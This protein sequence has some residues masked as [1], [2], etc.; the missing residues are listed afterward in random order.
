[1]LGEL[2][3]Q[4]RVV[5]FVTDS[6]ATTVLLNGGPTAVPLGLR[7]L[8]QEA[9]LVEEFRFFSITTPFPLMR[10]GM[11]LG[12]HDIC[13]DMPLELL[14]R[15]FD[16]SQELDLSFAGAVNHTQATHVWRLPRP[17]YVPKAA[18]ITVKYNLDN[19]SA[20]FS[21]P[22]ASVSVCS[23]MLGRSLPPDAPIPKHV[24]VPY[25]N[26]WISSLAPSTQGAVLT[27]QSQSG[28]LRNASDKV[29]NVQR[30]TY[31]LVGR[32][33]NNN[34]IAD[35]PGAGANCRVRIFGEHGILGVRDQTPVGV[36]FHHGNR[37][38]TVNTKLRPGGFYIA[39]VDYTTLNLPA[40]RV[41]T[42]QLGIGM[43]GYRKVPI[44][45]LGFDLR[46]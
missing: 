30:F 4:A 15:P 35:V 25:A 36:L 29:L 22:P 16:L 26:R 32:D 5:P 31:S 13:L 23:A 8:R 41:F 12:R 37:S 21:A 7:N 11:S 27:D 1:M 9:M 24:F 18:H 45:E 19:R 44:E 42:P 14:D 40:Q 39:D 34:A 28:D 38:W 20:L 46:M 6:E 2:I 17:M 3:D 33:A 43:V 10:V